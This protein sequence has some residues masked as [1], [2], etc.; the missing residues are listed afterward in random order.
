MTDHAALVTGASTGIGHAIARA[1][2]EDG[3]GVT[4]CSRTAERLDAA[5]AE[6]SA[7]GDVYAVRADVSDADQVN[8]LIAAHRQRFG[9]LD[10][11]VNNAGTAVGGPLSAA[12]VEHLDA[13]IAS[14]LRSNWLVTAAAIP[15]L[16]AAGRGHGRALV[17]T[18]SSILGRYGQARTPAYSASKA[19]LF[20][21]SQSVHQELAGS[22]VRVT[23]LAPAYVE[24]PMTEPLPLDRE[25]LIRPEDVAEAVRFLTR[26]SA[27]CAVPEIQM[28]R[29]EDRFLT[30]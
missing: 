19:A 22:G 20:A 9:R 3:Y 25:T 10:V 13:Q 7:H 30:A 15:L 16:E 21:L 27:N 23:T 18:S 17:V 11:L 29:R 1:L 6:L 24:T 5:A 4:I 28:L 14:N 12:P 8:N 2:L 26:L